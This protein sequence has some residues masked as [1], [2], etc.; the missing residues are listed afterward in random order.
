MV[1]EKIITKAA[2]VFCQVI[3]NTQSTSLQPVINNM[4][5]PGSILISDEWMGYQGLNSTYDHRIIDH[6]AKQYVDAQGNTTNSMEGVWTWFK[7]SYIGIYHYMSRKH[8]QAYANEISFRYNT[9]LL[10]GIERFNIVVGNSNKPLK[11]KQ[12]IGKI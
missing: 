4:V 7:R 9:R 6:R 3:K 5:K 11:Y 12:L 10:G 8:M 1:K 2:C